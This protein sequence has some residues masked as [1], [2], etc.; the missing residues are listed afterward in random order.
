MN[1]ACT[2]LRTKDAAN[3]LG[4]SKSTLE[5]YRIYGDGPAFAKIGKVVIYRIQDLDSWTETKI[6]HSTSEYNQ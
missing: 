1:T 5:K 4:L 2:R 6:K 3:Y